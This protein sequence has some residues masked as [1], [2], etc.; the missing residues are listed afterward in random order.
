DL[1][2]ALYPV[3]A[4]KKGAVAEQDVV[5]QSLIGVEGPLGTAEGVRIAKAHVCLAE[6]HRRPGHLGEKGGGD[7]AGITQ[8]E[9]EVVVAER[10]GDLL[11]VEREH[12][13]RRLRESDSQ[14]VAILSQALARA[15][16]ERDSVP[17]PVVDEGSECDESLGV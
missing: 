10:L 7:A 17:A 3:R 15:Q 4:G 6:V 16:V 14:K 5:D 1:P 13:P 11:A 2:E 8:L 9:G 12:A